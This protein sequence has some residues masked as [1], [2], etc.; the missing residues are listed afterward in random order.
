MLLDPIKYGAGM[1]AGC[2]LPAV[3]IWQTA[4]NPAGPWLD[5]TKVLILAGGA[6]AAAFIMRR[7]IADIKTWK[8]DFISEHRRYR[9]SCD[10]RTNAIED[11]A[12]RVATLTGL[13]ERRI[14]RLERLEDGR[15]AEDRRRRNRT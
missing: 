6:L 13:M 1:V 4:N 8:N 3:A 14:E 12:N 9:E 7:D 5:L 2:V 11:V 10:G 15:A